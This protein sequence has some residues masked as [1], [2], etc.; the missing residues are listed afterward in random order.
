MKINQS[1]SKITLIF[2][3]TDLDNEI[4]SGKNDNDNIN[5]KH[6]NNNKADGDENLSVIVNISEAENDS[7]KEN[8]SSLTCRKVCMIFAVIT[9]FILLA[10][11]STTRNHHTNVVLNRHIFLH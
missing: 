8:E 10:W 2:S 7:N 1:E 4:N 5:G 3:E 9:F 11:S 6:E